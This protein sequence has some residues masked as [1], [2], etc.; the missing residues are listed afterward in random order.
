MR[1]KSSGHLD[2]GK[3]RISTVASSAEFRDSKHRSG[4][5]GT[6]LGL[7]VCLDRYE[8]SRDIRIVP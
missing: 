3:V 8:A 5:I 1:H 2:H 6:L 4:E 7:V